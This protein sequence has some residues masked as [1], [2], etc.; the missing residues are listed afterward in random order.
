MAVISRVLCSEKE[1]E[2]KKK[3]KRRIQDLE[4]GNRNR[5][6]NSICGCRKMLGTDDLSW[7]GV[8]W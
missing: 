4:R 7:S 2:E 3:R 5:K 6:R 8:V 1:E